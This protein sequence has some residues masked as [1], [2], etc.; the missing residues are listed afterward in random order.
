MRRS[1]DPSSNV[2]FDFFLSEMS[3]SDA[4]GGGITLQRLLGDKLRNI[5]RFFHLSQFG[6]DYPPAQAVQDRTVDLCSWFEQAW[7]KRIVGCTAAMKLS[8]DRRMTT[9]HAK[10]AANR[11]DSMLASGRPARAIV[12]PQGQRSVETLEHL[13]IQ[14]PVEYVSW[15]MDDHVVR[16][17]NGRWE[18]PLHF[19]PLFEKHLNEARAVFVISSSMAE[20][21]EREFGIKNS[22]V[23]IP[24]AE[25]LAPPMTTSIP[26]TTR[27]AYFGNLSSWAADALLAIAPFLI[28]NKISLAVYSAGSQP[29]KT[30]AWEPIEFMGR[31][32]QDE[33]LETMR[34]YDGLVLPMSFQNRDK[35]MVDLN[36]ATRLSQYLASGNLVLAVG[37]D[38]AA[39]IR[40][41]REQQAAIVVT[42]VNATSMREAFHSVKNSHLRSR[43]VLRANDI[44]KNQLSL[45]TARRIWSETIDGSFGSRTDRKEAR[46]TL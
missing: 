40:Y 5:D 13:K 1:N 31:T 4:H 32:P 11:I 39:M 41:L 12:C 24:P 17:T 35:H 10:S 45:D 6:N 25:Q 29:T 37:P 20:F 16:H 33:L 26:G 3:V 28:A 7:L 9:V 19:R 44:V 30:S 18:Y 27:L 36:I 2:H 46:H 15:V 38:S 22:I 42:D 14:R 23:L 43:I 21:Y 34:S 8:Q